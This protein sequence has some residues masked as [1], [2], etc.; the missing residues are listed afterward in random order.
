M[1]KIIISAAMLFSTFMYSQEMRLMESMCKAE[2]WN[3]S[4]GQ[5]ESHELYKGCYGFYETISNDTMILAIAGFSDTT[6]TDITYYKVISHQNMVHNDL[7]WIYKAIQ[8]NTGKECYIH[9]F[10]QQYQD[11]YSGRYYNMVRVDLEHYTIRYIDE[12]K[13][14]F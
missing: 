7:H 14:G 12:Q 13:G 8:L 4:S 5:F 3:N 9:H 6:G 10:R 11:D 1:K 2:V